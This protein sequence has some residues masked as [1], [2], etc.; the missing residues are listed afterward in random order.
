[1]KHREHSLTPLYDA[2]VGTHVFMMMSKPREYKGP[3]ID[4]TVPCEDM[5]VQV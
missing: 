4:F 1:M 2:M 5:L 3:R